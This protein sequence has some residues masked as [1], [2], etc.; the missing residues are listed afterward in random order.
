MPATAVGGT[1]Q[2]P[3]PMNP[4]PQLLSPG[5]WTVP[6]LEGGAGLCAV[7]PEAWGLGAVTLRKSPILDY[8][9]DDIPF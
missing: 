2:N 5:V 7:F 9:G 6:R 8:S 3:I 1:K 4:Q